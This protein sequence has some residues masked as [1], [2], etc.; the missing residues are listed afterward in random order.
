VSVAYFAYGSNMRSAWLRARVPNAAV[1]RRAE[2]R[3]Y[4]LRF[5]KRSSDGSSKCDVVPADGRVVHGVVFEIP[6]DEKP[7]LDAAEGLG[8]GYQEIRCTVTT[9]EGV[10]IEAFMYVAEANAI[11]EDLLPYSWYKRIVLAGAREHGLPAAFVATLEQM[12]CRDDP[13]DERAQRALRRA[14]LSE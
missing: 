7:T 6:L 11:D 9:P 14:E 8:R 4:E 12:E 10:S 13:E 3:D 2:L 1:H 5:R